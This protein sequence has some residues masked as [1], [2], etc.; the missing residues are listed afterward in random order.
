MDCSYNLLKKAS[1]SSNFQSWNC[2]K[3]LGFQL[4]TSYISTTHASLEEAIKKSSRNNSFKS[5][6]VPPI[7]PKFHFIPIAHPKTSSTLENISPTPNCL[8]HPFHSLLNT[9]E[10]QSL[11]SSL[12]FPTITCFQRES[13]SITNL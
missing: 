2:L 11:F 5:V 7:P 8:P 4:P 9:L 13:L 10:H 6:A 1:T 12:N 3:T